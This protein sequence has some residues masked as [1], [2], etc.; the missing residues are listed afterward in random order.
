M[1]E[2]QLRQVLQDKGFEPSDVKIIKNG[3][4]VSKGQAIVGFAEEVEAQR[5]LEALDQLKIQNRI[6]HVKFAFKR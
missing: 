6:I 4:S 5:A 2:G 1:H 3:D